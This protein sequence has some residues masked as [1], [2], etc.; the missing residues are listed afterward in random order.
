MS[1]RGWAPIYSRVLLFQR[2]LYIQD[3]VINDL[4]YPPTIPHGIY[5][6]QKIWSSLIGSKLQYF[7]NI[8]SVA[9]VSAISYA[10]G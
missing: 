6:S 5:S 7:F 10:R 1:Q 3:Y 8:R 9:N 2:D 4:S